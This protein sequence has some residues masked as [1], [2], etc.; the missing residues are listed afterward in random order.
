MVDYTNNNI[1]QFSRQYEMFANSL[2][3]LTDPK[4]RDSIC[5]QLDKLERKIIE[6]TN[7]IY[8]EEYNTLLN[9]DTYLFEEEKTRLTLLIDLINQRLN[10]VENRKNN[11]KL[12]VGHEIEYP[13]V[14]GEDTLVDLEDRIKIINKYINNIQRK[15]EIKEELEVLN[16]KIKLAEEKIRINES[17][18]DELETKMIDLL[19]DAFTKLDLFKLEEEKAEIK[20]GYDD[21]KYSL[22]LASENVKMA[23]S[24]DPKVLLECRD[25]ENSVRKD[26]DVYNEKISILELIDIYDE[27][28]SNY[29][30]LLSKREKINDIFQNIEK[31]EIYSYVSDEVIKQ[32]NTIK[33]EGQDIKTYEAFVTAKEDKEKILREIEIENNSPKFKEVLNKLIEN[34]KIKKEQER[35]ERKRLLEEETKKKRELEKKRQEEI[36]KR[37]KLIEENRKKEIEERTKQL[38]EEKERSV[39]NSSKLEKTNNNLFSFETI[40]NKINLDEESEARSKKID[41]TSERVETEGYNKNKEEIEKDLFKEFNNAFPVNKTESSNNNDT[42]WTEEETNILESDDF[43]TLN[44]EKIDMGKMTSVI[45]DGDFD[46][47][48]KNFNDEKND[49]F[50]DNNAF[51]EFPE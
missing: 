14:L 19:K 24:A 5:H 36:L 7:S 45:P 48:M 49:F 40:K 6:G 23:E 41:V 12:L 16:N 8:E 46:D 33:I 2:E 28:V 31:T 38:L 15:A 50:S 13:A 43:P 27:P 29:N 34:E 3:M 37:Q 21:L 20:A 22:E 1:I 32:Y 17:L 10:Y 42:F 9:R 44:D 39:L 35:L 30:E 51:P 11:H 18:N 26:Y 25:M 47:Y 4:D